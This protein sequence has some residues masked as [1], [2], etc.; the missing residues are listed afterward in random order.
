MNVN[1]KL[2][3]FK[4]DLKGVYPMGALILVVL[5]LA[6]YTGLTYVGFLLTH[7]A[8]FE[9]FA[10]NITGWQFIAGC[11]LLSFVGGFFKK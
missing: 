10:Y 6:L 1:L 3:G 4:T 8:V 9:V 7:W 2:F 11:L 5:W